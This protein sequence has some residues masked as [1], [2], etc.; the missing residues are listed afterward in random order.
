MSDFFSLTF[1]AANGV[2]FGV[3]IVR[4]GD[5][6]GLNDCLVHGDLKEGRR[7]MPTMTDEFL[8][9]LFADPLIEFYDLRNTAKFGPRGQFVSRYAASTLAAHHAGDGL[10]LHCGVSSWTVDGRSMREVRALAIK[11]AD[12][13]SLRKALLRGF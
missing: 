12:A 11:V 6:Y 7:R 4:T 9:A 13:E 5:R 8:S 10:A 3:R 2:P 1:T